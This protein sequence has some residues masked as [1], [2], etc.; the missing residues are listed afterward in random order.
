MAARDHWI[1]L[2]R[3]FLIAL[4]ITGLAGWL[5]ITSTPRVSSTLPRDLG[6]AT[7]VGWLWFGWRWLVRRHDVLV[8][9]DKRILRFRG[10]ISTDVPMMRISKIT[11]MHYHRSPW[12]R[13]SAT[14]TSRSRARARNRHSATSSGCPPRWRTITGCARSSSARSTARRASGTSGATAFRASRGAASGR[15]ARTRRSTR[16][17]SSTTPTPTTWAGTIT[18]APAG[19]TPDRSTRRSLDPTAPP[20]ASGDHPAYSRAIP[21]TRR[22]DTPRYI[23]RHRPPDP[24]ETPPAGAARP[25]TLY[26]SP[27]LREDPARTQSIW[28]DP[29]HH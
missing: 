11:D 2:A 24:D 17:R 9:T 20:P 8:V 22:T 14:A 12:G 7:L 1:V 3:P 29:D 13:S 19:L 15:P 5:L 18:R 4:A 27:D 26:K 10:I 16:V 21:V 23:P 6:I 28:L 25:E